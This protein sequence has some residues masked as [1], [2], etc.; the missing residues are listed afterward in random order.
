MSRGIGGRYN[1]NLALLWLSRKPA[2][3]ALIQPLAWELPY[4]MGMA[5]GG[6][7]SERKRRC[8]EKRTLPS[9]ALFPFMSQPRMNL[10]KWPAATLGE[11]PPLE[12]SPS[13]GIW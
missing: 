9:E 1:S 8:K 12:E 2:A 6:K 11:R 7:K 10:L 3:A 4:A 13:S 5:Q